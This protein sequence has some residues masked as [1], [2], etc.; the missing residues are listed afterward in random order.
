MIE[1]GHK[2]RFSDQETVR[3]G[4]VNG[5]PYTMPVDGYTYVPVYVPE[6]DKCLMVHSEN[7]LP[8]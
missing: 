1:V 5:E 6:T 2:I 3:Q 7:I 8:E 4:I